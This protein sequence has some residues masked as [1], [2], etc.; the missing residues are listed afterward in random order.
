LLS[1]VEN[2]LG[3]GEP[4][5]EQ[6]CARAS[7]ADDQDDFKEQQHFASIVRAF[8]NYRPWALR[9]VAKLEADYRQ[10]SPPQQELLRTGEKVAGMRA[11]IEANAAILQRIV[12]P[13]RK[14]VGAGEV[15]GGQQQ[16]DP[17]MGYHGYVPESD[18]DKLQ[19][20]IKQFVREWGAEGA[21]EREQAHAP[22][23]DALRKALPGGA[24][25]GARVLLP[26]AGMGR[27]V[28]EA[29]AQGYTAQGSEFSYFMLIA[30]N[31]ILNGLQTAQLDSFVI[32]P[33]VL[34]TCNVRLREDQLRPARVPDVLPWSL[35]PTASMSMTAGDFL[36]VY[37]GQHQEWDAVCT[38]FFIDTAHDV[39]A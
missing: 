33:W 38:C 4:A 25:A 9:K 27:L 39:T 26:G 18:M 12:A 36:D 15:D 16:A 21:A 34:S 2:A 17:Q 14:H 10:L 22:L 23:F 37:S 29:A 7:M 31:F 35:P 30:S 1:G 20:T 8:D 24:E 32:H 3:A 28:W 5:V 13:H 6:Q 19:S 11:C